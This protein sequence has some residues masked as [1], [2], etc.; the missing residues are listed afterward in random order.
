MGALDAPTSGAPNRS[1][2]NRNHKTHADPRD[3]PS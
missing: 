1:R 2:A 3:T